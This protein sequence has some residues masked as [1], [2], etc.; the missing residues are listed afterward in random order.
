MKTIFIEFFKKLI[1]DRYLFF[2]ILLLFLLSLISSIFIGLSIKVSELQLVS[3]Y[4]AYGTTNF[5]TD[6]WYYLL[7]FIA[8]Q[9]LLAFFHSVIAIKLSEVRGRSIAIM[10]IWLGICL[11][12]LGWITADSVINVYTSL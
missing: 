2:L 5:Y 9:L 11:V 7:L 8:F 6:Q 10:F 1:S 3:H 4:T 12:I